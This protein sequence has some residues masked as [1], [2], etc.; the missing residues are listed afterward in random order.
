M[1]DAPTILSGGDHLHLA[2][3]ADH[4]PIVRVEP[5]WKASVSQTGEFVRAQSSFRHWITAEGS[6]GFTAEANR[7]HLYVSL[8]C[9]WAHRTLIVRK[10]K[11]LEDI[12]SVCV[13]D[14]LLG[15]SG[16][17]NI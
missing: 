16:K 11:G 5:T 14:W 1:A 3:E 13:V 8:A 9:P 6:S 12:I 7:Y 10:L 4:I 15:D 2:P 17:E